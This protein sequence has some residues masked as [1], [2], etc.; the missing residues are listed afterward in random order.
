MS[1]TH[2]IILVL[3]CTLSFLLVAPPAMAHSDNNHTSSHGSWWIRFFDTKKHDIDDFVHHHFHHHTNGNN[4]NQGN[5]PPDDPEHCDGDNDEDDVGC[6]I[7]APEFSGLT[8]PLTF[9]LTGVG[10]FIA[11]KRALL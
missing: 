9:S 11:K 7:S 10:L 2:K 8:G 5:D 6:D 4:N 3:I 1:I